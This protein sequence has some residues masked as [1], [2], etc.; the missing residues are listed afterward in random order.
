MM[1]QVVARH[2]FVTLICLLASLAV[3]DAATL[4]DL[5]VPKI[6]R[7]AFIAQ[8]TWLACVAVWPTRWA[9]SFFNKISLEAGSA[10]DSILRA[11]ETVRMWVLTHDTTSSI[12]V[13]ATHATAFA[14][15]SRLG[16]EVV[17]GI[18]V[19]ACV[20]IRAVQTAWDCGTCLHFWIG[21]KR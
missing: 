19:D 1:F 8:C 12:V 3:G 21:S 13:E 15:I 17:D 16:I 18:T 7:L 4:T 14:L 5:S 20:W 11:C 9:T 6:S 10:Y 2:T